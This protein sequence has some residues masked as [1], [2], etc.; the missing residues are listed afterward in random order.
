[1]EP[2]SIIAALVFGGW[3]LFR[4][5]KEDKLVRLVREAEA[6]NTYEL[7]Q[8]IDAEEV[9]AKKAK[10]AA[11]AVVR[12]E[13]EKIRRD[14]YCSASSGPAKDQHGYYFGPG[15]GY[16]KNNNEVQLAISAWNSYK[17]NSAPYRVDVK[18]KRYA[19]RVKRKF[20]F[21]SVERFGNPQ[22]VEE[23]NMAVERI[24]SEARNAVIQA[25][26]QHY[27][28]QTAKLKKGRE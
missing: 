20:K 11:D 18:D 21:S 19:Q 4:E 16:F 10:D 17:F 8:R 2:I 28:K 7:K 6:A 3:L 9:A 13:I 27:E 26:A 5:K 14:F 12:Q 22:T 25:V 1:M 23:A 15:I 24:K